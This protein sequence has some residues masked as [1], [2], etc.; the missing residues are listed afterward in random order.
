MCEWYEL[1]I[2][3]ELIQ[4]AKES[5]GPL[6][7]KNKLLQRA[8]TKNHNGRIYPTRVLERE[9][10]KYSA[11]VDQRRALGELDHPDSPIVELKNVS[12][13]VTNIYMDGDEVRGDIEVLNTPPGKILRDII[14]QEVK[15]GISSRGVG[16]LKTEGGQKYVQGDFELIAF[17]AVSSPSTPGAFLLENYQR[18]VVDKYT[19]LRHILHRTVG[20]SYFK[21][22]DR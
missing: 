1:D 11:L 15:I 2:T 9:V 6:V 20:D 13:L 16:S 21:I 22:G 19:N 18:E 12:H 10:N 5:S 7:L 4:E 3:P 14:Q 17:D 8:N